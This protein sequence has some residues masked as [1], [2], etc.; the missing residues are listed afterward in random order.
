M[1]KSKALKSSSKSSKVKAG[2]PSLKVLRAKYEP[3]K[4]WRWIVNENTYSEGYQY[5]GRLPPCG[6]RPYGAE[7]GR[8]TPLKYVVP[9]D[10]DIKAENARLREALEF[11]G[12]EVNYLTRSAYGGSRQ[13]RVLDDGG[14]FARRA[15]ARDNS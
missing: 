3:V 9:K 15:L 11:Y 4:I 14:N 2:G 12:A 1:G 8:W 5:A 6:P 10:V 7:E 13:P